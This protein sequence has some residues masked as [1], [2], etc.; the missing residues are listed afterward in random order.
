MERAARKHREPASRSERPT[1]WALVLL[2]V[3]HNRHL[4]PLEDKVCEA[5][6]KGPKAIATLDK[7]TVFLWLGKILYGLLHKELFSATDRKSVNKAKIVPRRLLKSF[8][9]HQLFLQAARLPFQFSPATPASRFIFHIS[10]P[11]DKLFF[12][13]AE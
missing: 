10:T 12:L 1:V 2:P 7:L 4:K 6:L 11:R 3:W 9:L 5:T 13:E 8:A